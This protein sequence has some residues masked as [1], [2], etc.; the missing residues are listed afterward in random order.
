MEHSDVSILD[1]IESAPMKIAIFV[2]SLSIGG[3]ERQFALLARGLA[4]RGHD[5]RV[6]TMVPSPPPNFE[7]LLQGIPHHVLFPK[8]WLGPL[9]LV[10]LLRGWRH[11]LH[12][13]RK[14]PVD[15]V[16]AALEWPNY[17]CVRACQHLPHTA[18]VI[19]V[20]HAADATMNWKRRID[21][22]NFNF[23]PFTTYFLKSFAS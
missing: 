16:Y 2:G 17:M 19:G 3:A 9:R 10:Q 15:V 11:V 6:L 14:D 12:H 20:R 1:G 5:V 21:L 8:A 13:L 4:D 22:M 7:D 18:S 23:F